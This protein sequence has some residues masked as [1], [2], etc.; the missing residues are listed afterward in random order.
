LYVEL[1][2]R[3]TFS[4]LRAGSSP[5]QL[6]AAAADLELPRMALCDRDGFYGSVRHYMTGRDNGV[7]ALVGAELTMEDNTVVPLLVATREGYRGLSR[8]ITTAK[9]RAPKGESRVA[10]SELAEASAGLFALTGDEEGPVLAGW[11][12]HGPAGA[13]AGCARLAQ[14]F[15]RDRLFVEVQR[16]HLRGE[17]RTVRALRDLAASQGLP[18][19]ATNGVS[20]ATPD[21]RAVLD[22][23]TCIRQHTHL[24]AA[25]RLLEANA[26]RHL[27]TPAAMAALFADLPEA[28]RNTARL[29]DRLEF[30]MH[31]LGYEFPTYDVP[32]DETMDS[33]L[34]KLVEVG[35]RKRYDGNPSSEVRAKI[36]QELALIARLKFA[37]YFLVVWDIC[38]FCRKNNILVQGRGSAANS[39]VC[40][41]L[42][43][44]VID[45]I[46]QHLLFERFL[47]EGQSSW[48]DIDLDLPSGDRREA[49]IQ[50]IYRRYAPRG[51]AM[52]ANVIAYRGRSA[53]RELGKALDLP[54]NLTQRFSSLYAN[55]DFPQTLPLQQQLQMAGLPANH[56]RLPALVSLYHKVRG[57]PRHLGQH[58]GGMIICR[59][60]LD[61][62][63][64]LENASM[65][66]RVVAQWD[67][68]DCADLGIIKVDFL[69]LGMMAALQDSLTLCSQRGRPVDL[70]KISKDDPA[71][72][73]LLQR[74]DTI[75]VFQVESRAQMAT[76]PR[77]KPKCFYDVAV[78][79]AIVRPG[80]IHG[81]AVNPYLKCRADPSQIRYLDERLRPILERTLGVTLFQEQI[82]QIAMVLGN[83]TGKEASDLRRAIDF[84]RSEERLKLMLEK[85]RVAM[86]GNGV[87]KEAS[88][89]V[90]TSV[91]TF[92]LY[93]FPESHALSFAMIAYSSSWLKVHR[94]PEFYVGLINNYPMGFY[95]VATLIQDARR[96]GVHVRPVCCAASE[97][98]TTVEPDGA[99]RIGFHRVKGLGEAAG[100]AIVAA[101]AVR[102]FASVHDFLARTGLDPAARRALAAAGALNALAGHR[103]A[104]LWRVEE[105]PPQDDLFSAIAPD[106]TEPVPLEAMTHFERIAA[107]YRTQS[108]TVGDHPM[109]ALRASLPGVL[110][111]ADLAGARNGA[112]VTVAGSVICRQ[113]PGTA[114]GF[115]FVS[116]EDE[117]GI[118]NAV[119]RPALFEQFRLL[120]TQESALVIRGRLQSH[121]GV[122]HIKAEQ[123]NPLARAELPVEASHDFH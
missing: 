20:Y 40:Y 49:A 86:A 27:K 92:A 4:F 116:L 43:I 19:L 78:Q 98:L 58:S 44:T 16:H 96:H 84:K 14:I 108:L 39:V 46:G 23:F 76:L 68:E 71:T 97:W 9:L 87:S 53:M 25:G 90:L 45:P 61:S 2:A 7:R 120:I 15:G 55:G 91:A 51:A 101:R 54:E 22:A 123:V 48:P 74:A 102:P 36:D 103:R 70:A 79:V 83:F 107:D 72:F 115:V 95:S 32:A 57:Q 34:R 41:A 82:L 112:W 10:W 105:A 33:Y 62:I 111:A 66:G 60:Q 28:V 42:E 69:G 85:L 6:I 63:V 3:S 121:Q 64:P 110:R 75:G 100:R 81:N 114:K 104:A 17:D 118:A 12:E 52:T 117:T 93:G 29:A 18:L 67:K 113:R 37:G 50:E 30:G 88:D 94:A 38:E 35:A 21:F 122:I 119:V 11:R 99:I 77:L 80:P 5:E 24:D 31:D 65:P 56:P 26:E 89:F 59:G 8:L 73:A 47:N 1:H 109:K 13:A 106:E